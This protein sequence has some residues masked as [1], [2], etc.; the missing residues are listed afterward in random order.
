MKF[1]RP[2]GILVQDPGCAPGMHAEWNDGLIYLKS[3]ELRS[4]M[5]LVAAECV[6]PSVSWGTKNDVW[7]PFWEKAIKDCSFHLEGNLKYDQR[8]AT[9]YYMYVSL[10]VGVVHVKYSGRWFKSV[11][12][13]HITLSLIHI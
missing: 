5:L 13:H 11:R 2:I 7:Q 6:V 10:N 8:P 12:S 4:T 1:I 9:E 3:E